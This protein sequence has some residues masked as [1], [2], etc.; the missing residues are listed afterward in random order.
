MHVDRLRLDLAGARVAPHPVEEVLAREHAPGGLE[1]GVEQVELLRRQRER[2]ALQ[3]H[4]VTRQ[5]ER[6]RPCRRGARLMEESEGRLQP[7]SGDGLHDVPVQQRVAE[8]QK[9]VEAVLRRP[10]IP[11][12]ESKTCVEILPEECGDR[13]EIAAPGFALMAPKSVDAFGAIHACERR[14]NAVS[15]G[16]NAGC[17]SI[18]AASGAEQEPELAFRAGE[19]Q[20][21]GQTKG[22]S[23]IA[24]RLVPT[25]PSLHGARAGQSIPRRLTASI[26]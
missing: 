22:E 23:G 6:E 4:Q 19:G 13:G 8:A 5:V 9:S 21:F 14:P 1:Q 10:T 2:P 26:P 17:R 11:S 7:D 12:G 15:R 18:R 3:G 20:A 25:D 24:Q 16:L